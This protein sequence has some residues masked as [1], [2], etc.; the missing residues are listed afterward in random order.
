M[1][2]A[3]DLVPGYAHE[4]SIADGAHSEDDESHMHYK[5]GAGRAAK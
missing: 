3:S 4:A 5:F 1:D 2:H